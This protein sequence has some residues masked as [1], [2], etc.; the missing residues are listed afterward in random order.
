[1]IS[2][3]ELNQCTNKFKFLILVVR[4]I[5]RLS[6]A[7]HAK[8]YTYQP[9]GFPPCIF[10]DAML[11]RGPKITLMSQMEG[12]R[13][14]NTRFSQSCIAILPYD[15]CHIQGIPFHLYYSL[16]GVCC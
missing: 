14:K 10:N 6:V 5:F 4:V 15:I 11:R 8:S 1:M 2:A 3:F 16:L 12:F 9:A 13:E 7:Q